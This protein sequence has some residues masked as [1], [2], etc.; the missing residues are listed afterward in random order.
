VYLNNRPY[1]PRWAA[2]WSLS[3]VFDACNEGNL[4]LAVES[5]PLKVRQIEIQGQAT[6]GENGF[7]VKIN[8]FRKIFENNHFQEVV[9]P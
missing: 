4:H 6:V 5:R 9:R 8:V 3:T 1:H 2:N 7:N